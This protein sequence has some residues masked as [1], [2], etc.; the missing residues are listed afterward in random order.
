MGP[1][2][3]VNSE[4]ALSPRSSHRL[5]T[6]SASQALQNTHVRGRRAVSTGI[7]QLDR[8]LAPQSLPG[9]QIAGGYIRGKVTEV[10]GPP[11][12]GK[13]ALGI[14]A[15]LSAL[16]EGQR[17]VWVDAACAPLVRQRVVSVVPTNSDALSA[18]SFHDQFCYKSAST[19]A[20]VLALFMHPPASFPPPNTSLL[21]IDSL[22]TL[23]DNAYPRN[24]DDRTAKK[25][26]QSRWA[27]GRRSAV[28]SDLISTLAKFAALHDI[29][30]LITSQTITRIRAASRALLVPAISG[31]E[32]ENN[33]STRLVLFRDW[34][35]ESKTSSA[36]DNNRL[37]KA[38][39]AGVVKMNGVVF[40]EEGAVGTVVPFMIEN[41]VLCDLDINADDIVPPTFLVK[42]SKTPKRPF[43]EIDEAADDD[44]NSDEL[45]GWFFEDDEVAAEGLLIE[46]TSNLDGDTAETCSA[47][48]PHSHNEKAAR[49]RIQ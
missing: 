43:S 47:N 23:I 44:P 24:P 41:G 18:D 39:F 28:I 49:I 14:Q 32:W 35:R 12:V 19:L 22:A 21:V 45:Y 25:T 6:I 20:H 48:G 36:G 31:V 15:A 8:F 16:S 42:D 38:R 40:A 27:A 17:V 5:P 37:P 26:D 33:I 7:A 11:G 10:F 13:T 1:P 46:E 2:V 9:H 29:A 34:I 3:V 4:D 30:I